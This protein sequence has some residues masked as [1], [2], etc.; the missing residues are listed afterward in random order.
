M[1]DLRVLFGGNQFV[2]S[3]D[4]VKFTDWMRQQYPIYQIENKGSWLS[5]AMCNKMPNGSHPISNVML[6]DFRLSWWD[7]Y[8]RRLIAVLSSAIGGLM[9]VFAVSSAVSRYRWK[10]RYALLA[11]C[12]RHG[13]VRGRKLQSEWTYDACFIYDET[14][15]SVSEWVGDLVLKLETDLRLRL[16][17]AE[18]DAPVG[19]NMLDE[20]ASAIDKSRHA[21]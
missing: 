15:S 1:P 20:A 12:I 2:C 18:R 3:C 14:D 4:L 13:L 7:C 8:S 11:F 10:L 21:V 9:V 6:L 19:S 17:E 5:N 16:Y